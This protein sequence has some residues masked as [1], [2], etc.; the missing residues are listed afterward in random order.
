MIFLLVTRMLVKV[1]EI[2]VHHQPSPFSSFLLKLMKNHTH[3]QKI[4]ISSSR[5][6]K[7]QQ[8][9]RVSSSSSPTILTSNKKE[10]RQDG[11]EGV[12]SGCTTSTKY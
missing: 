12:T 4:K 5:H 7:Q 1:A 2:F 6:K 9:S 10:K 11:E 8:S 3:S